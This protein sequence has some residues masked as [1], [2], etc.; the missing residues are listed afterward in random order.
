MSIERDSRSPAHKPFDSSHQFLLLPPT[1]FVQKKPSFIK[2]PGFF[3]HVSLMLVTRC[4]EFPS[5]ERL[6][7]ISL[8]TNH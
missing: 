5:R 2:K 4:A 6:V 7:W 3:W 8:G 1:I